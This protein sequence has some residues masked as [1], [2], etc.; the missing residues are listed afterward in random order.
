MKNNAV[1]RISRKHGLRATSHGA[2]KIGLERTT[3]ETVEETPPSLA[4][5]MMATSSVW[6]KAVVKALLKSPSVESW[7]S[8]EAPADVCTLRSQPLPLL[9]AG[10]VAGNPSRASYLLGRRVQAFPLHSMRLELC[11][12]NSDGF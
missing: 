6:V 2:Q 3:E 11:F 7:D 8:L 4:C 9:A 10:F 5:G 1:K 12:Q